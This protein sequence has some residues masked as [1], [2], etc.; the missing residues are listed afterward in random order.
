MI[1][2]AQ[3]HTVGKAKA[4]GPKWSSERS[5]DF[6]DGLSSDLACRFIFLHFREHQFFAPH[7]GYRHLTKAIAGVAQFDR[8]SVVQ[9]DKHRT[10]VEAVACLPR[11]TK[12]MRDFGDDDC[13]SLKVDHGGPM[14]TPGKS[15][16]AGSRPAWPRLS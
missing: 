14:I 11:R 1:G 6:R 15:A 9:Q 16:T 13:V 4:D 10:G 2:E 3:E 7:R 8:I 12:D 5:Q